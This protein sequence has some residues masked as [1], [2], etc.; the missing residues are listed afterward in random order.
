MST[1][2]KL[3]TAVLL[4]AASQAGCH[5]RTHADRLCPNPALPPSEQ[6]LPLPPGCI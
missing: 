6:H 4:L 1:K 5:H 2:Q 3:L